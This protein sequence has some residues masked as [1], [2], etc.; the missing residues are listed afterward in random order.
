M[1]LI[2]SEQDDP[3]VLRAE[4][5][6][7]LAAENPD[8]TVETALD[9]LARLLDDTTDVHAQAEAGSGTGG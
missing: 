5:E 6:A 2:T 9:A 3:A 4:D 1:S 8:P 7:I